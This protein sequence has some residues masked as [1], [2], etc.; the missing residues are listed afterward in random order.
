VSPRAGDAARA[1]V[2]VAV[3][4]DVAF[5]V[6][7]GEIDRWWGTGPRYRLQGRGRSLLCF[8]PGVNGRL[9]EKYDDGKSPRV[10]E[11]GRVTVWEPGARLEFEWRNASFSPDQK[12]IVEV[13]FEPLR[14][15]TR[16]TVHHHGWSSLPD[17]HPARHGVEG[18]DF[19]RT[20]GM[21][22]GKLLTM[23]RE[24]VVATR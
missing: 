20:I 19:S 15:G 9:F 7:T 21:W 16:V 24:H 11:I 23:L 12:T 8:E 10:H 13:R 5:E 3:P 4:P 1:E 22:W 17:G 18:A 14:E 6:F 2:F